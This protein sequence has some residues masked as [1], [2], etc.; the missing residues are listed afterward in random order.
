MMKYICIAISLL[1]F[2]YPVFGQDTL[3]SVPQKSQLFVQAGIYYKTF[4]GKKYIEPTPKDVFKAEPFENHQYERFNKVPTS[5]F[6]IGLLFTYR[7][8]KRLGI[9]TG[10][11]YFLRRDV[12]INNQDTVIK[13]FHLTGNLQNIRNVLKYDY[14]YNYIEL[15]LMFQYSSKKFTLYA[16]SYFSIISYKH[17][18]Y[19]YVINQFPNIPKWTTSD[20]TMAGWE[21]PLKVFPTIQA[22]YEVQIN[23]INF[24]PYAALFYALKNQDDLYVLVGINFPL[25]NSP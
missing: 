11:S 7:F 3:R 1:L 18:N 13:Y 22:S 6:N 19:T 16:G 5:G 20:K 24:M 8:N 25:I 21:M 14:F 10:L 9:T 4:L 15:P 2:F 23:K 17:A 12:F